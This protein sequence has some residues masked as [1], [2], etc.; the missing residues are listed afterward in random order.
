MA[1]AEIVTLRSVDVQRSEVLRM[2]GY[3]RGGRPSA[4]VARRIETIWSGALDLIAPI[5][6]WRTLTADE[7]QAC[8]VPSP[9]NTVGVGLVTI[10]RGLEARVTERGAE[11]PLDA[12][13]LDA[14]GSVAAEATA[15]AIN[16]RIC[17]HA[18]AEG[19][20]PAPRISPGYGRW[21]IGSQPALLSGLPAAEIGV[22]LTA[23]GMMVPHKSVSFAVRF[24]STASKQSA[25]LSRCMRCGLRA[26]AHRIEEPR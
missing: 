6:A 22:K 9:T 17:S 4:R 10:G 18:T 15:D 21:D 12:L 1:P 13:L 7:A 11:D 24:R 23:S 2:L 14:I 19:H 16:A 26:C 20:N 8:G 5:G 25:L 3:R